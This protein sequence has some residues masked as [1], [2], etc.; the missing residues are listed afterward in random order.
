MKA[1]TKLGKALLM[2]ELETLVTKAYR[3]INA[4]IMTFLELEKLRG[5]AGSGDGSGFKCM[6]F[7]SNS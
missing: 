5:S 7:S 3:L 2:I 1:V 6:W 4:K